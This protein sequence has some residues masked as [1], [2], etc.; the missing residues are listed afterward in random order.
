[1][2]GIG[3]GL[4]FEGQT[5]PDSISVDSYEADLFAKRITEIPSNLQMRVVYDSNGNAEYVCYAPR[6]LAEDADG[7]LLQKFEY[8]SSNKCISRLIAFDSYAN[9]LTAD[10]A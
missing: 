5:K 10:Y 8:D 3:S 6:A 2:G 9:Y 4:K 7:W 1:M